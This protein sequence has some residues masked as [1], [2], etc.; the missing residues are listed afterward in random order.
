MSP[1]LRRHR[2][3]A[4]AGRRQAETF[5]GEQ[6]ARCHWVRAS[7]PFEHEGW[8]CD[9]HLAQPITLVVRPNTA[10]L[11]HIALPINGDR[12]SIPD[13][14]L[15]LTLLWNHIDLVNNPASPL[16]LISPHIHQQLLDAAGLA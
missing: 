14:E 7:I 4:R 2:N 11:D 3:A 5:F 1:P 15:F 13:H 9:E 6:P 10:T 12:S 8:C 16:T